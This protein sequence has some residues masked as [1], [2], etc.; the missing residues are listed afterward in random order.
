[1][2]LLDVDGEERDPVGV[3]RGEIVERPN[4]GAEGRSGV[5]A[6][7]ER[8]RLAVVEERREPNG[9]TAVDAR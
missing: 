4:L 8:D 1:M 9:A 5:R 2:R 3:S 6:E 7:D